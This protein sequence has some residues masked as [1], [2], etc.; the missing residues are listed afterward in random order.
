MGIRKLSD[1]VIQKVIKSVKKTIYILCLAAGI[2]ML[3][4]VIGFSVTSNTSQVRLYSSE[5]DKVM[6]EK[7]AFINTV[8]AGA[9]LGAAKGNYAAYV[10]EMVQQY[11]DVSAVYV[12][13][14]EEGT[15]YS[16]GIMTY[17]SGGWIPK[18]DFVVS[19]RAWYKG[20]AATNGVYVS[21]PY[22]D[23]QSGNICITLSKKISDNGRVIGTAGLDMYLDD[24]VTLIQ[25]SYDGGDYVFLVS[26]EGTVLTHPNTDIALAAGSAVNIDK[27]LNGKYEATYKNP[28]SSRLIFDYSGGIKLA[29]SNPS[30]VTGWTVIAVHSVSWIGLMLVLILAATA[31]VAVIVNTVSKKKLLKGIVPLFAPLEDLSANVRRISDGELDYCFPVDMQSEEVNA[32]SVALNDTIQNLKHYISEIANTVK[33]ISEKNLD[34]TVEGVYAGDYEKIKKALIDIVNELNHSFVNV[35]GQAS[36]VLQYSD[37]LLTTSESVAHTAA[38]QSESVTT[39]SQEMK[40]LTDNME[41]IAEFAAAIKENT[42]N[43]NESLSL[44]KQ[45]MNELVSA[46]NEISDCY[47]E[48]AGFVSAINS[49]ANQTSLLALNASIEAARSGEAGRGFAVVATEIGDLSK[50]SSEANAKISNAIERSLHSVERGM[51]LVAEADRTILDSVNY[52]TENT[53]MVG[54]IV[55]FVETQKQSADEIFN[56][57]SMITEIVE[58][59]AAAAQ[60]NSAISNNMGECAKS[61]MDTISNFRLKE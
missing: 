6:A 12:C 29:M 30:S 1:S 8:A 11:D 42:N 51:T 36:A 15:V 25:K 55:G 5:I 46:M 41:K 50:S 24:L 17:M 38:S 43:T 44:G 9:S 4:L 56:N 22:V 37:E 47:T 45:Q 3:C 14:E 20:A 13:V 32:L 39:A 49:I 23:E 21:E 48:I 52:S 31:L 53:R 59:N 60:E 28:L 18:S 19:D 7:M 54:E 35:R 10:D 34:F 16:D 58:T 40:R 61:L 26:Q 33:A 57:L 2:I 27:A